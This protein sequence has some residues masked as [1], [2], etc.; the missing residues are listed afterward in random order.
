MITRIRSQRIGLALAFFCCL[1]LVGPVLAFPSR[2]GIAARGDGGRVQGITTTI[3]LPIVVQ[4][5]AL[6][7]TTQTLPPGSAGQDYGP[8]ALSAVGGTRP[9]TWRLVAGEE[10]T[11]GFLSSDGRLSGLLSVPGS[12][13]LTV[14]VRDSRGDTARQTLLLTVQPPPNF[15]SA[16]RPSHPPGEHWYHDFT[17]RAGETVRVAGGPTTLNVTGKLTIRPGGRLQVTDCAELV[18]NVLSRTQTAEILGDVVNTCPEPANPGGDLVMRAIGGLAVGPQ[19]AVGPQGT[20]ASSGALFIGD[21]WYRPRPEPEQL[22]YV[23][24]G[25]AAQQ[26]PPVCALKADPLES[27]GTFPVTVTF[28]AIHQDPDGGATRPAEIDYGDGTVA[29]GPATLS[30]TYAEAGV[31]EVALTVK[32]DEDEECLASLTLNLAAAADGET[33][34]TGG[35][36]SVWAAVEPFEPGG[37]VKP[38]GVPFRFTSGRFPADAALAWELGEAESPTTATLEYSASAPGLTT[39]ALVGTSDEEESAVARFQVYSPLQGGQQ[40]V[41]DAPAPAQPFPPLPSS[42]RDATVRTANHSGTCP[43]CSLCSS[44]PTAPGIAILG[45]TQ[46]TAWGLPGGLLA[47]GFRDATIVI[48]PEFTHSATPGPAGTAARPNGRPGNGFFAGTLH[49]QIV[50]CGGTFI[51]APGG[52]GFTPAAAAGSPA[53]AR[54]GRGGSASGLLLSAPLGSIS[55]CSAPPGLF[56]N[57]GPLTIVPANGGAGGNATATET[58]RGACLSNRFA[59][60]VAG[61]GG[62][63]GGGVSYSAQSVCYD[64]EYRVNIVG[65]VSTGGAGGNAT[66]TGATPPLCPTCNTYG[67]T[68]GAARAFAGR[69]GSSAW[70]FVTRFDQRPALDPVAGHIFPTGT[71]NGGAGGNVTATS[72]GGG[73]ATCNGCDQYAWAGNGGRAHAEGG[74]AGFGLSTRGAGGAATATSGRGGDATANPVPPKAANGCPGK[75]GCDLAAYGGHSRWATARRGR[76][77]PAGIRTVVSGRGGDATATGGDGGDGVGTCSCAGGD[78]GDARAVAGRD[79]QGAPIR[80]DGNAT[81]T[82]GNGGNGRHNLKKKGGDGGDGGKAGAFAWPFGVFSATGGN[83]GNGGNGCPVGTGGGAG[84]AAGSVNGTAAP[85]SPGAA[86]ANTCAL[87]L[88]QWPFFGVISPFVGLPPFHPPWLYTLPIYDQ[89]E[90][91]VIGE[92]RVKFQTAEEFGGTVNYEKTEDGWVRLAP[93]GIEFLVQG[94]EAYQFIA[95]VRDSSG[96]PNSILLKGLIDGQIVA[97]ATNRQPFGEEE[98]SLHSEQPFDTVILRCAACEFPD[99]SA[100]IIHSA[101]APRPGPTPG[102]TPT[103]TPT[104]TPTPTVTPGRPRG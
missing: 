33:P 40:A 72:G 21:P 73:D 60:A 34:A 17:V 62:M 47:V 94:M 84:G 102:A 55:F 66:A 20:I 43:G 57:R 7:I 76:G 41:A 89:P 46:L 50:L 6:Q 97:Q 45:N 63:A 104:S 49:G 80:V 61:R 101:T 14:E 90:G 98:L 99:W 69:G 75:D 4:N 103:A 11:P 70:Y 54:A 53:I 93:G 27:G 22:T 39:V 95:H 79:P 91:E 5:V 2:D 77:A 83:G 100:L 64:R 19:D 32:D 25:E 92:L 71:Y 85:G 82:G 1:L 38:V 36:P 24:T 10:P 42:Y 59:L 23:A 88:F 18:L 26:I 52:A 81:A 3:Y 44:P 37:L 68:G 12:Y 48:R 28:A 30:H 29:T 74:N 8:V 35:P 9:Y 16:G 13:T 78:G 15:D 96:Q 67:G 86:G 65:G 58:P 87:W 51:G 56:P 31:Y